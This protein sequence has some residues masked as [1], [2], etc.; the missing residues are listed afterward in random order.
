MN[1]D[2]TSDRRTFMAGALA[3]L[4][5]I[6]TASVDAVQAPEVPNF[7]TDVPPS[8]TLWGVIVFMADEPIEMTLGHGN[9][10]KS[11]RGR[12]QGQRFCASLVARTTSYPA[13]TAEVAAP[14]R[15]ARRA[16]QA[17]PRRTP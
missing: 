2:S 17:R 15:L 13:L 6:A 5:M 10:G 9:S 16:T 11:Y 8:A 3:S 7:T 12:F 14:H 1:T 4:A